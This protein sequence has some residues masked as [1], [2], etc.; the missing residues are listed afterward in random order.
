[1]KKFFRDLAEKFLTGLC[2]FVEFAKENLCRLSLFGIVLIAS[3]L[4]SFSTAFIYGAKSFEYNLMVAISGEEVKSESLNKVAEIF[5]EAIDGDT[6]EKRLNALAELKTNGYFNFFLREKDD[7]LSL[8]RHEKTIADVMQ[9]PNEAIVRI[10][11][12]VCGILEIGIFPVGSFIKLQSE[13]HFGYTTVKEVFLEFPWKKWWFW[14]ISIY[15]LLGYWPL[16]FIWFLIRI[17]TDKEI[18]QKRK[19]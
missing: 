6:S 7:M 5:K 15:W 2:N 3:L 10:I 1:M 12:Y 9:K 18:V 13:G 16:F 19:K 14:P 8:M 17:K 4:I 11:I